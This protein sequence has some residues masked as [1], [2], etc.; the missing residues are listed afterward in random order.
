MYFKQFIAELF[1]FIKSV[2]NSL[3]VLTVILVVKFKLCC[4]VIM[5][6]CI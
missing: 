6:K 4:T 1:G 3:Q 5:H 2:L